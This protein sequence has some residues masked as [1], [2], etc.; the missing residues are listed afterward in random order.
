MGEHA[1]RIPGDRKPVEFV[2]IKPN[3]AELSMKIGD[4]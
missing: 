4:E 3:P 2:R 1:I